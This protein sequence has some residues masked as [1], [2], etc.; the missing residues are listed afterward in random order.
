MRKLASFCLI[1]LLVIQ[2]VCAQTG[3]RFKN[4]ASEETIK[5]ELINNLII[6]PLKVNNVELSF[7]LDT[8]VSSPIL[9]NIYQSDSLQIRNVEEITLKGLGEGDPI[10]AFKS[11]KNVFATAETYN[12]NQDFYVVIDAAIN[13]S[14]RLG[15]PV[16]GII[17][18]DFFRD[19]VVEINYASEK[20][21]LFKPE[22]YNYRN[23]N[24][25]NTIDISLLRKKPYL[26]AKVGLEG[27]EIP[28]R[29]LIDS[30]SSDALWLFPNKEMGIKVP[31][32]NFEDFLGRGLSGSVY[33]NKAKTD[34]FEI[35]DYQL[36]STNVAFPSEESIQ[37][38]TNPGTR[39]GSVGGE[40]LKRFNVVFD[41]PN[42][43]VT[44][45]KNKHFN[46]DFRFNLSGIELMH[47]GLRPVEVKARKYEGVVKEEDPTG[48][49]K[50]LLDDSTRFEL[51]PSIEIAEIR[52]KSLADE[53]GL[54]VGDV[55]IS[56]NGDSVY[57]KSLQE[58]SGMLNEKVGK[59]IR[60]VI[61]RNG[62][63]LKFSF[64]LVDVL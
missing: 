18:Y 51:H 59:K 14:P 17:G 49:I 52:E 48:A 23:C 62:I 60:L 33:G 15:V 1:S 13:F 43:K 2:G 45:K 27:K 41:Y 55:I 20:I 53:V 30:G 57:D 42:R 36:A 11:S 10:K 16:H 4:G 25:C 34:Y 24:R 35:G 28:V 19:F 22:D 31:V 44:I 8:G 5:F 26:N 40:I 12:P 7:I 58:I 3:F 37:H 32:K 63:E 38:L 56:V 61:D 64:E 50:I 9:F 46:D 21:K 39:N 47:N 29:L 6:F 54:K